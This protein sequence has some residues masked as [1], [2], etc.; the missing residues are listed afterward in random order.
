MHIPI[1][2][3][4]GESTLKKR[5]FNISNTSKLTLVFLAVTCHHGCPKH[6]HTH[7]HKGLLSSLSLSL[8]STDLGDRHELE[9][10]KR[11]SI[12]L[13]LLPEVEPSRQGLGSR[14]PTSLKKK[15]S[16]QLTSHSHPKNSHSRVQNTATAQFP[17]AQTILLTGTTI[18]S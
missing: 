16:Y 6:T 1:L 2:S 12:S 4:Q 15:N 11:K 13:H 8:P 14:L 10:S 3:G 9:G 18:N 7:T 17:F 5:S